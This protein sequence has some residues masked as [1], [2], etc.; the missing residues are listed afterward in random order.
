[1]HSTF[2]YI[3]KAFVYLTKRIEMSRKFRLLWGVLYLWI[4][5]HQCR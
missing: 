4:P 5:S 3:D 1:M 2:C